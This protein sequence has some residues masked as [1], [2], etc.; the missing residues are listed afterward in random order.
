MRYKLGDSLEASCIRA[1]VKTDARAYALPSAL[2]LCSDLRSPLAPDE[3][4]LGAPEDQLFPASRLDHESGV[5]PADGAH[6]AGGGGQAQR[7]VGA[8]AGVH[9]ERPL[10]AESRGPGSLI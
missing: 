9:A 4:V 5:H 3:S 6:G 1:K 2:P 10:L 8:A 7:G